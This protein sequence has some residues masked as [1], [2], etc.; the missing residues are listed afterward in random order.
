MPNREELEKRLVSCFEAVFPALD[1]AQIRSAHASATEGW[2][3]V[4]A[5][6]L[7]DV[8]EEE[9]SIS[10]DLE[11]AVELTSFEAIVSHVESATTD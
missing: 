2:D 9:F 4:A 1:E 11:L 6:S 8:V 3:S 10:L 7:I 5:L